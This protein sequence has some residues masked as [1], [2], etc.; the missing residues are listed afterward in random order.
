M[1]R[2]HQDLHGSINKFRVNVY[3]LAQVFVCTVKNDAASLN[4]SQMSWEYPG[5]SKIKLGKCQDVFGKAKA[6]TWH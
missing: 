1:L 2:K 3:H 4:P 6:T 5:I